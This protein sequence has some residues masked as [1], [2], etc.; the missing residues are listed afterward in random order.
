MKKVTKSKTQKARAATLPLSEDLPATHRM[1]FGVRDELK[2][3]LRS[4]ESK[5]DS[6]FNALEA[7]FSSIDSRFNLT[8]A[9]FSSIESR[10]SS[11]DA[12]FDSMES[13]FSSIDA[14]FDL[15][16]SKFERLISE[17]HRLGVIVEEQNSR[18]ASALDTLIGFA[19]RQD[20][21]ENELHYLGKIVN[22]A[23]K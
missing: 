19:H 8:D 3:D 16:D 17:V 1:L 12:R 2:A 23:I 9:K 11:I 14:R 22:S 6:R 20:R 4:L 15:M 10:F 7:K 13:R 18:N 5:M 21:F